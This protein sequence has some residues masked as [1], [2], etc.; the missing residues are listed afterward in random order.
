MQNPSSAPS[1]SQAARS[2]GTRRNAAANLKFRQRHYIKLYRISARSRKLEQR[3]RK[4][5]PVTTG[6]GVALKE[7][8]LPDGTVKYDAVNG[9]KGW[10][11]VETEE[12]LKNG[13]IEDIDRSYYDKLANDA[14]DQI[15][16]YGDYYAFVA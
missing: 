9:T 13:K 7:M 10:R 8:P 2:D 12:F 16:K 1:A 11:W 6:G 3:I 15:N 14:I 4:F 5:T